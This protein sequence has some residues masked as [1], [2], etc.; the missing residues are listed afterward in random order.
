VIPIFK[1]G[2]TDRVEN[3]RPISLLSN[4][5]K[6]LEKIMYKRIMDYINKNNIL[7]ENQFGFRAGHSTTDALFSCANMLR[8]EHGNKNKIMGIFLD[9]SKAFDTVDHGILLFKLQ[10]YGVRGHVYDW[11]K[12]YLSNRKQFTV[13]GSARSSEQPVSIGV[14]QGS[15]L[16]PLLF[17]LYINDIRYACSNAC[18]K[19]FA[20]DS[21]M[22]VKGPNLNDLF[23][24][25]NQACSE[26]TKWFSSNRLTIN[27]TKSTFILFFPTKADEDCIVSNSFKISLNNQVLLREHVVKFLGKWIDDNLSFKQHITSVISKINSVNG[28]LYKRRDFIPMNCRKH[29]YFALVHSRI[30]YGIS[31]YGFA[32]QKSLQSLHISCNKVLRTLQGQHKFY[33]I[34]QLYKNYNLI[35]VQQLQMLTIGCMIYKIIKGEKCLL[36]SVMCDIFKFN[37]GNHSYS[38]RLVD[39]NF[40]YTPANPGFYN[41][42]A[43]TCCLQWNQIPIIIRNAHCL[44]TFKVLYKE[45]LLS[46]W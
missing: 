36:S 40:L 35:P 29:L 28:M 2:N 3:Y 16:G 10:Y 27:Y 37:Q 11:F 45:H 43:Y 12:S 22:Y 30:H 31:V 4:M 21:N 13:I 19:L 42:L 26:I 1:K 41:S 24:N 33:N 18:L 7:Y 8:T 14:P 23:Y 34:K 15:I 46:T 32:T 39:T 25:A 17:L 9:L 5:S 44:N 20:D 6:I 38:T